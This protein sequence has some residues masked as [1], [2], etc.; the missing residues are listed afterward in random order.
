MLLKADGFRVLERREIYQHPETA[1]KT[2]CCK[3]G[4]TTRTHTRVLSLDTAINLTQ[5][6]QGQM[7]FNERSGRVAVVMPTSSILLDNGSVQRRVNIIRPLGREKMP[8]E[9]LEHSHWA[10]IDINSFEQLWT[11]EIRNIPEFEHEIFYVITGLLLPLWNTLPSAHM[12]VYRLQYDD[13]ERILGRVIQSEQLAS[14]CNKLGIDGLMT[15]SANEIYRA[16]YDRR[17]VMEIGQKWQLR[18]VNV[19]S[20]RRLEITGVQE[21]TEVEL[22]K[23]LGCMTEMIS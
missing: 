18:S 1:A 8:V 16:V 23:Q 3:I 9:E 11:K 15:L 6:D 22:L 2:T 7:M 13:G 19:M 5:I 12:R 21:K 10:E 17:Q 4:K 14:V 20:N